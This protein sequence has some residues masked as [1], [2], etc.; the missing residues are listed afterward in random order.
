M[1]RDGTGG[2]DDV[3]SNVHPKTNVRWL[4][5]EENVEPTTQLGGKQTFVAAQCGIGATPD[6]RR[7]RSTSHSK[8]GGPGLG[9]C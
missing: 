5:G 9:Y 1:L 7:C 4:E 6:S 8:R 3:I 2:R